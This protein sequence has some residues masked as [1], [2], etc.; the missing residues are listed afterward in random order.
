MLSLDVGCVF[1]LVNE[2]DEPPH[3]NS[4]ENDAALDN[5]AETLSKTSV[6]KAKAMRKRLENNWNSSDE[7][8]LQQTTQKINDDECRNLR[9]HKEERGRRKKSAP[10]KGK[11]STTNS[12]PIESPNSNK[13]PSKRKTPTEDFD[14]G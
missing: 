14:V 11:A 8:T 10:R 13:K 5:L 2:V 9:A 7:E 6:G 4:G 3:D 1:V 12:S